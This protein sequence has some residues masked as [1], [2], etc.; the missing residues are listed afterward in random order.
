M[1]VSW[2]LGLPIRLGWA[3]AVLAMGGCQFDGGL[4]GKAV[5]PKSDNPPPSDNT[6]AWLLM[7]LATG[8][9]SQ[10]TRIDDLASNPAYRTSQ[11]VF[12]RVST[13]TS[14]IGTSA[15]EPWGAVDPAQSMVAITP[16]YIG[17][18]E[19]TRGQWRSLS[20]TTPWSEVTPTS[21]VGAAEDERLPACGLSFDQIQS[22]C[23]AWQRGG[24]LAMP[25]AVQWEA[26]C[27]GVSSTLFSW[28]TRVD[29][30]TVRRFAVVDCGVAG[31][32]GPKLVGTHEPNVFGLYDMHGNVWEW[33]REG[34]LRGGSWHDDLALARSAN[35]LP[36]D[37][38][39]A[40]ALAGVRLIYVP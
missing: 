10:R 2:T 37:R 24:T 8:Q 32:D 21:L 26:A 9:V 38:T 34:A 19:L 15:N 6:P 27:R 14:P 23:T 29:E 3:I 36:A 33:T 16:Y 12:S 11:M 5:D 30:T 18:F 1:S 4:L 35:A 22:A 31:I 25:T 7:D 13:P 28:G 39:M 40:H 17:V 20:E